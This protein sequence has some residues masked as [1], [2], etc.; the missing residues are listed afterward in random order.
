LIAAVILAVAEL[1]GMKPEAGNGRP[2]EFSEPRTA[3]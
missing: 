3:E 2:I 1:V